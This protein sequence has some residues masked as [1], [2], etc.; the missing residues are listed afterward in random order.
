M[1]EGA[2]C[3]TTKVRVLVSS[4]PPPAPGAKTTKVNFISKATAKHQATG[5]TTD[6]TTTFGVYLS[7]FTHSIWNDSPYLA[8][9]PVLTTDL[10]RGIFG[11]ESEWFQG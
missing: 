11:Y 1:A 6:F 7:N 5:F 4:P 9:I 2:G 8:S 3:G 10:W